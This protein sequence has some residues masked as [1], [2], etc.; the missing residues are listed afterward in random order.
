MDYWHTW[1][2]ISF[3]QVFYEDHINK[4]DEFCEEINQEAHEE[5]KVKT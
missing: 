5:S 3:K 1:L 4:H 2:K